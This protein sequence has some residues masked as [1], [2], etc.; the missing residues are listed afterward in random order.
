[1]FLSTFFL[2]AEQPS[3]FIF[4]FKQKTAYEITYGDWSSDVCSSDLGDQESARDRSRVCLCALDLRH[5]APGQ[6]RSP[7]C[8]DAIRDRASE[9]KRCASDRTACTA[10]CKNEPARGRRTTSRYAGGT[11]QAPV[12]RSLLSRTSIYKPRPERPGGLGVGTKLR[13]QRWR[14]YRGNQGGSRTRLIARRPA[15]RSTRPESRRAKV[16]IDNLFARY[17]ATMFQQ[18]TVLV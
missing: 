12:R 5:L 17:P 9:R 1:M 14:R 3:C 13:R 10:W 15:L 8:A 4:F 6:R 2:W 16:K 18:V 11:G 7:R